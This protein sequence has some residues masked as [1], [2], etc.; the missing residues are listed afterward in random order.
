MSA[1]CHSVIQIN[2]NAGHMPKNAAVYR[3][4]D[5]RARSEGRHDFPFMETIV[6][7]RGS[8][9]DVLA[10]VEAVASTNTTVLIGGETGTGKEIIARFFPVSQPGAGVGWQ[11]AARELTQVRVGDLEPELFPERQQP[12]K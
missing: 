8:L 5:L 3:S 7:R 4:E 10:L 11:Q 2:K 9:R 1:A 12:E 6:G